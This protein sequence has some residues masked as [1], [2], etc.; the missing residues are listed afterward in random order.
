MRI[1]ITGVTGQDGYYLANHA[2]QKGHKVW[3]MVR[4]QHNPKLASLAGLQA[5]GLQIV[6][7]DLTDGASVEQAFYTA[8]PEVVFNLA[9][10]TFIPISW[11]QPELTFRTN[12][13]GLL[14]VLNAA[15]GVG[16]RVVQA[17]TSEMFGNSNG[18]PEEGIDE[19]TPMLPA[20]PYGTAKLAAHH[21]CRNFSE[22]FGTET[23]SL[24]MFNHESPRRE[25]QFVTRKIVG[26]ALDILRGRQTAFHLGNIN[27][28]RDWGWA[29]EYME[30][31]LE[32]GLHRS[33]RTHRT[34]VLAT[35]KS[36]TVEQFALYCAALLGLEKPSFETDQASV[37]K[38]ELWR[39]RGNPAHL[40]AVYGLAPKHD[41]RDVAA[42]L[43]G[44][45]LAAE[46]LQKGMR[47]VMLMHEK[48]KADWS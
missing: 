40:A 7:G 17:S 1:L 9:A 18:A 5:S 44:G 34:A 26:Q 42:F 29:P 11:D 20:S 41:W 46:G 2:L 27:A 30:I 14:H 37:R 45:E 6:Q 21:L 8:Q 4:G 28:T 39:L 31:M 36:A 10:M 24:I 3:G 22:R 35:G 13:T 23:V 19:E 16:A 43:V 33:A 15:R 12:V 48:I 25:P 47:D 38:S 32:V